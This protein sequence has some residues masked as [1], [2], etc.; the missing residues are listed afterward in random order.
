M[1][2]QTVSLN[3]VWTVV[4]DE[5]NEGK[6]RGFFKRFP[7]GVQVPV[8][9]VWELVR[10]GY[11]GVGWYATSFCVEPEW[12]KG[13]LRL[14]FGAVNYFCEAWINGKFVGS[15]EGGYTPFEFDVTG[16]VRTGDNTLVVRVIN[17]CRR[18]VIEGFRSGAPLNA[19]D[20]PTW[21]AGWYWNC[22]LYTSPSP[23]D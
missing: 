22:L 21:K 15:H 10:P 23:R 8:P 13:C 17:P 4:F 11:D 16:T 3:G 14:R 2:R 6:E 12:K 19:S 9:G 18:K 5:K 1:S 7:K 20:C